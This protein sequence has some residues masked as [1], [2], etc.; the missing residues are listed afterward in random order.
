MLPMDVVCVEKCF[1]MGWQA[2]LDR[3][4]LAVFVVLSVLSLNNKGSI[5]ALLARAHT[6]LSAVASD[7]H[8]CGTKD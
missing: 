8:A 6:L 1:L 2:G 5:T 4:A 7:L 3:Q